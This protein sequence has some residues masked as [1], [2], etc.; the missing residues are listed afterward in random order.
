MSADGVSFEDDRE[1]GNT[2]AVKSMATLANSIVQVI[3]FPDISHL[4]V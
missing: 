2:I 1:P 4:Q 3:D